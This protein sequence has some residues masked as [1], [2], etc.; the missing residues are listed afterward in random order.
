MAIEEYMRTETKNDSKTSDDSIPM[1][2][3]TMLHELKKAKKVTNKETI[4]LE[5]WRKIRNDLVHDPERVPVAV[6]KNKAFKK[7][8]RRAKRFCK[9]KNINV[10]QCSK[11]KYKAIGLLLFVSADVE[12]YVVKKCQ[13]KGIATTDNKGK[14]LSFNEKIIKLKKKTKKTETLDRYEKMSKFWKKRNKVLHNKDVCENIDESELVKLVR[15]VI[16]A[17]I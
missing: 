16:K 13:E 14:S 3:Y 11:K 5:N 12:S 4:F 1:D 6:W 10:L 17:L 9:K 7:Y 8:L 2:F 15:D